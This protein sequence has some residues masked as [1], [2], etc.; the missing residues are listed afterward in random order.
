MRLQPDPGTGWNGG[1]ASQDSSEASTP[2]R[3]VRGW[4]SHRSDGVGAAS[5]QPLRPETERARPE[6]SPS[7]LD[8]A[9]QREFGPSLHALADSSG[10]EPPERSSG[11]WPS[12]ET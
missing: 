4:H 3:E 5:V 1:L 6:P 12:L 8:R 10:R 7:R 9:T 2:P 11:R